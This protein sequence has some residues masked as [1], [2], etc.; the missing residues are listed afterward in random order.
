[1]AVTSAGAS[2]P[3]RPRPPHDRS[4]SF[5]LTRAEPRRSRGDDGRGDLVESPEPEGSDAPKVAGQIETPRLPDPIMRRPRAD[6]EEKR[7][8]HGNGLRREKKLDPHNPNQ[9]GPSDVHHHVVVLDR[10]LHGL[11]DIGALHQ[12][13]AVRH[14][15]RV[16]TNLDASRLAPGLSGADVELPAVPGTAIEQAIEYAIEIEDHDRLASDGDEFLAARRDLAYRGDDMLAHSVGSV[17]WQ[18]AFP[19]KLYTAVTELR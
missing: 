15:H 3:Q 19:T 4:S 18:R 11:G 1:M 9:R 8:T 6:R 13:V 10:H 16:G 17:V 14:F 2:R 12:F 7:V 5:R